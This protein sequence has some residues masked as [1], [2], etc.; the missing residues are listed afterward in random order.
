M[1]VTDRA[2]H[3]F[4]KPRGMSYSHYRCVVKNRVRDGNR[5]ICLKEMHNGQSWCLRSKG[6][7]GECD[8]I[9]F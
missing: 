1:I 3:K 9:P 6:H 2:V 5:F 7:I 4:H 8:D